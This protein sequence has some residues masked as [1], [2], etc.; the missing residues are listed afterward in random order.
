MDRYR[1]AW[2]GLAVAGLLG[3]AWMTRYRVWSDTSGKL[4]VWDGWEHRQCILAGPVR[5]RFAARTEVIGPN[6]AAGS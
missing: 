4:V 1:W 6:A 3:W 2:F 5:L